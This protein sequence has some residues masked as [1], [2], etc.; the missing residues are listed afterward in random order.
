MTR[1]FNPGKWLIVRSGRRTRSV[2]RP[3]GLNAPVS[4]LSIS[5]KYMRMSITSENIDSQT[6]TKSSQFQADLKY[7]M[8]YL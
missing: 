1:A 3:V 8:S 7:L 2:R 5:K 4:I 6:I